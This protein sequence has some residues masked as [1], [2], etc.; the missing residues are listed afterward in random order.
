MKRKS[1]L[2]RGSRPLR[3]SRPKT[4]NVA[5]KKDE[6]ARCFG[7]AERVEFVKGLPCAACGVTGFSQNA[8]IGREGAGAGR[9]ANADQIGPLCGP[10]YLKPELPGGYGILR[11]GCHA[12][13]DEHRG[14]FV[15]LY[16]DFN[17]TEVCEETERVW[18]ESRGY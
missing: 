16:S 15:R 14:E 6:F 3:R 1:A 5:R 12:L 11:G 10:H 18:R 17:V 13:Y 2:S 9:R 8:H 7:S 4:K